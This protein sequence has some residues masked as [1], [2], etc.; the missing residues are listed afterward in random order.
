MQT[1]GTIKHIYPIQE[2]GSNG[3][4]KRDLILTTNEQY[5]QHLSIQFVNDKCDILDSFQA[6]QKVTVSINLRGREWLSPDGVTKYFNTFQGWRIETVNK[7]N[8]INESPL[9]EFESLENLNTE[10]ETD[11]PF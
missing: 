1:E 3:F 2:I 8:D 4:K 11:L 7:E 6:G 9:P 5:A 10:D